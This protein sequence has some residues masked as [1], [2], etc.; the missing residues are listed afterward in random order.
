MENCLVVKG[1]EKVSQEILNPSCLGRASRSTK[2]IFLGKGRLRISEKWYCWGSI[3]T[4]TVLCSKLTH[5]KSL[6]RVGVR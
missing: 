1:W 4:L 2:D 3:C 6:L 5:G